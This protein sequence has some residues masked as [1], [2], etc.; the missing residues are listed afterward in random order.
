MADWKDNLRPAQYGNT[1]FDVD[2][3]T[4]ETGRS[5]KRHETVELDGAF[6]EDTG[7]SSRVFGVRGF[8]LGDDY[9]S[10]RDGLQRACETPAPGFPFRPGRLL[11]LP[12]YGRMN[13]VCSRISFREERTRGRYIE[14]SAEWV[15][16]DDEQQAL[17]SSANDT[18]GAARDAANN[19]DAAAGAD[20]VEN[21]E[22]A[23]DVSENVRGAS[24]NV[25]QSLGK[26]MQSLDIFSGVAA[27]AATLGRQVE[28]LVNTASSL[29]TSPANLVA[30][31]QDTLGGIIAA[32]DNAASSLA[33][34]ES[35]FGIERT[36]ALGTSADHVKQNENTRLVADLVD[37]AA[38][39]GMVRAAVDVGFE[40]SNEA[41]A[42]RE[43]ITAN[44]DTLMLSVQDPQVYAELAN[45]RSSLTDAVPAPD[46]SL[47]SVGA[48]T[49][50]RTTPALVI[51]YRLQDDPE[52]DDDLARRN[53]VVHPGFVPGRRPL[54]VL[55]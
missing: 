53:R 3:V 29:A 13:A 23:S 42:T 18:A 51:A 28:D 55:V 24:A 50:S 6:I 2:S 15:E 54:E 1:A 25:L 43:R 10:R 20:V 32:V 22:A 26:A 38:V 40:S 12:T 16:V 4:L 17:P 34:Y 45:M 48:F 47:P 46:E 27:E 39:G 52:R 35:L 37:I 5:T 9:V 33:A 30:S 41:T 7:R 49:P 11:V 19:A 21:L 44:I 14:F 36:T 8:L 31:V